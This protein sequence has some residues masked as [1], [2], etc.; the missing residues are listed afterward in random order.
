ML[1]AMCGICEYSCPPVL[2]VCR[3]ELVILQSD[4][5]QGQNKLQL[6]SSE[7]YVSDI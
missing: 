5:H 3:Y 7:Q 4:A 6:G 2:S 1:I